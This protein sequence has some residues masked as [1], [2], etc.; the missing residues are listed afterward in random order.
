MAPSRTLWTN[1]TL[2]LTGLLIWLLIAG[3][4]GA[5][6]RAIGGG[7]RGGFVVSIAVGFIGAFLG[8]LM[9]H[10]LHLPEPLRIAVEGHPF[11]ILWAIIGASLF[12][13]IIHFLSGGFRSHPA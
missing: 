4:C 5:I 2:N 7:T 6:G 8:A 11:P 13:A 3:V 12:V 9:A 1:M 10:S